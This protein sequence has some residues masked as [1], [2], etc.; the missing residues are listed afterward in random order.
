MRPLGAAAP[1]RPLGYATDAPRRLRCLGLS[2]FGASS[3]NFRSVVA[4]LSVPHLSSRW[5][6]KRRLGVGEHALEHIVGELC[7]M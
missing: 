3:P 1:C 2:V 6:W 5:N 7:S 4:P